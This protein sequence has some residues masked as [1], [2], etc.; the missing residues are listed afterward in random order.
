MAGEQ[1]W[2]ILAG[3]LCLEGL[4][5]LLAPASWRRLISTAL[6]AGAQ[7]LRRLGGFFVASG[8]GLVLLEMPFV[9]LL[10][11]GLLIVEG[12]PMLLAPAAWTGIMRSGLA[13]R[14]G[15][16]RF[17]GLLGVGAGVVVALL[18]GVV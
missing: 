2:I 18:A 4:L 5:P 6:L 17:I 1:L 15:Q 8:C 9:L 3:V 16:L 11:G 7:R 13:L 14:D 10:L 12:L